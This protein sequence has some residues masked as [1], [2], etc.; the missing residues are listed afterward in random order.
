MDSQARSG[1]YAPV[2]HPSSNIS[3]YKEMRIPTTPP[4]RPTSKPLFPT[5]TARESFNLIRMVCQKRGLSIQ[6]PDF[7]SLEPLIPLLLTPGAAETL[8]VKIYRLVRTS[9]ASLIDTLRSCLTDYQNPVPS[10][11]LEFQIRL[12]V[13]E[14]SDLEFVPAEFRKSHPAPTPLA[15]TKS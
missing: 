12:A 3:R 14:A 9:G 13:S 7:A 5:T 4:T 11:T 1:Y 10:E 8:A 6:E 2:A 15:S